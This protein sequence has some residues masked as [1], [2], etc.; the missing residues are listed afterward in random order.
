[1]TTDGPSFSGDHPVKRVRIHG[2]A[3]DVDERIADDVVKMNERGMHTWVSCQGDNADG[4][5]IGIAYIGIRR[6]SPAYDMLFAA[7][8]TA[9]FAISDDCIY[10]QPADHAEAFLETATPT[11]IRERNDR[12]RTFL[13]HAATLTIDQT[14]AAYRTP[15]A[16]H[17]SVRQAGGFCV[18]TALITAYN[19][20]VAAGGTMTELC[21]GDQ[22]LPIGR[23]IVVPHARWTAPGGIVPP[24]IDAALLAIGFHVAHWGTYTNH[25][26]L[27][28][29]GVRIVSPGRLIG[30][31]RAFRQI[32]LDYATDRIAAP[33]VYR[34]SVA[35]TVKKLNGLQRSWMSKTVSL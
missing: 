18:D 1:M 14:G 12:F 24:A 5:R 6:S 7:A 29:H 26:Y 10:A 11:Q 4:T 27:P 9:G 16:I 34:T 15:W 35:R 25:Y 31:S 3:T 8:H 28:E 17:P 21:H 23:R 20:W 19:R 13:H 30:M 33:D 22:E 32:F 2:V